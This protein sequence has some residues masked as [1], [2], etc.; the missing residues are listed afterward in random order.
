MVNLSVG[1]AN[2][3]SPNLAVING[4]DFLQIAVG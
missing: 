2:I 3:Q 4:H 1:G